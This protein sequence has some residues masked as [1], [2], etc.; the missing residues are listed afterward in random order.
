MSDA[1]KCRVCGVA[2]HDHLGHEG[3]C[4]LVQ[5]WN[6]RKGKPMGTFEITLGELVRLY[7]KLEGRAA[8]IKRLVEEQEQLSARL[9]TSIRER[10]FLWHEIERLKK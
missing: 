4:R 8:T 1:P 6:R 9:D 5:T 7:A 10:D 2:L 3:L